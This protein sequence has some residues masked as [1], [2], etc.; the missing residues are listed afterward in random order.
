MQVADVAG[1]ATFL[2]LGLYWFSGSA[3][4]GAAIMALGFASWG[5]VEYAVHRWVFHG[6]PSIASRAHARHHADPHALIG[7][8]ALISPAL[9]TFAYVVLS[10]VVAKGAAALAVGSLYAG[11]NYYGALHH[12]LHRR[13]LVTVGAFARLEEAHR[14]HHQQRTKNFGVTTLWWDRLMGSAHSATHGDVTRSQSATTARPL[15]RRRTSRNDTP[16]AEAA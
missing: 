2:A 13:T 16:P 14:A 12:L 4:A 7:M 8:P 10:L 1:A 15:G 9:A 3:P 6:R 11:Y 5:A